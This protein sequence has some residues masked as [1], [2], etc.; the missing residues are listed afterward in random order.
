MPPVFIGRAL[1]HLHQHRGFKSNRKADRGSEET[2]VVL[3]GIKTLTERM[4]ETGSATLGEFL[5]LQIN[6]GKHARRR[7]GIPNDMQMI[8]TAR[9]MLETEFWTIWSKQLNITPIS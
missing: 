6:N 1:Y 9:S 5:A 8:F 3:G 7:A 2:G 4:S